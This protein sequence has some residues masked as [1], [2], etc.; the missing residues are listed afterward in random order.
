MAAMRP[1]MPAKRG[2][3]PDRRGVRYPLAV[4]IDAVRRV[5][6]LQASLVKTCEA[7]ALV[8]PSIG[9]SRQTLSNWVRAAKRRKSPVHVAIAVQSE[10]QRLAALEH[11]VKQLRRANTELQRIIAA[12]R[13]SNA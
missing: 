9:C 13:G 12:V 4:R 1:A 8:A 10:Q 5:L 6:D 2:P 11:E 7:V 3:P